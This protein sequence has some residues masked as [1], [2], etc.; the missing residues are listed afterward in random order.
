MGLLIERQ[1]CP[2]VACVM[3]RG[4]VGPETIAR[5]LRNTC[6]RCPPH[7]N[8]EV[9]SGKSP[10]QQQHDHHAKELIGSARF[11]K[12]LL[13][14]GG[15]RRRRVVINAFPIVS[16]V[17][18]RSATGHDEV[19]SN[20]ASTHDTRV[21]CKWLH[22]GEVIVRRI[23]RIMTSHTHICTHHTHMTIMTSHM[24]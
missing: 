11:L 15:S 18:P 14:V 13:G 20:V 7:E 12:V 9:F 2:T 16:G 23:I 5:C 21:V 6:P 10:I 8:A 22:N 24:A 4:R 19:Q 1:H 3:P 17:L